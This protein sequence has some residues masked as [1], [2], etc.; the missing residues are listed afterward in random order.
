LNLAYPN[1]L[2]QRVVNFEAD[3]NISSPLDTKVINRK[4][5]LVSE[6]RAGR[7]S[8]YEIDYTGTLT[9]RDSIKTSSNMDNMYKKDE[10]IYIAGHPN[11]IYFGEVTEILK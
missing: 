3:E 5:L 8:I 7:L 1:G 4:E 6:S 2:V 9:H 11:V 10:T